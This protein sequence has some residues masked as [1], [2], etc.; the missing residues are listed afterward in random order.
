MSPAPIAPEMQQDLH[1]DQLQ[2]VGKAFDALLLTVYQLSCRTNE[3]R[4]RSSDIHHEL[5]KVLNQMP[6]EHVLPFEGISKKFLAL[7]RHFNDPSVETES[8]SSA[9]VIKTL[10]GNANVDENTLK[11]IVAG[12]KGCKSLLRSQG[13]SLDNSC[14]L[15]RSPSPSAPLE[16]DFTTNGT[17]GNLRCPLSKSSRTH[18]E[19][20]NGNGDLPKVEIEDTCGHEDLDPIKAEQQERRSSHTPSVR[21]SNNQCPVSRCPIRFLDQH[22]PEEIAEYVEQHKHEIPRS[23]AICVKRYQRDPQNMR[24]LDAKYGGLI[25]MING[26]SVKHQA[27]L[28]NRQ[29]DGEGG[30]DGQGSASTELVEK[31]A[32]DVDPFASG[33]LQAGLGAFLFPSPIPPP[34]SKPFPGSVDPPPKPSATTE[35]PAKPAGRCPFGHDAPKPKTGEP[36]LFKAQGI[37]LDAGAPK[38]NA[39]DLDTAQSEANSIPANVIFNGPVFFGYSAEQTASLMQQLGHLGKS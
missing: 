25:N 3:L 15:A 27:F 2:A 22:S 26:L 20:R 34:A 1:H 9:D 37:K 12:I 18:S 8:L 4:E 5:L 33:N 32:D 7:N 29:T 11:T 35:S 23:H 17:Q 38:P 21:S 13:N 10:T 14:I 36:E 6:G 39:Q 19:T 28:P 24:Q 16:E 31:W 30:G